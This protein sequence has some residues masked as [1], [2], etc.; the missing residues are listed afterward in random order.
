MVNAERSYDVDVH[1]EGN[2]WLADVRGLEGAHTYSRS[3]T[4]LVENIHEVISL[5]NDDSGEVARP[6]L[7]FH[8]VVDRPPG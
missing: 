5:V 8:V 1:R 6:A 7:R 2:S 4:A 3:V